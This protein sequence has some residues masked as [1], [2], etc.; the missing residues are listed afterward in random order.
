[1]ASLKT[2]FTRLTRA[3]GPARRFGGSAD[4]W[5][6]RYAAGG[7]AGSGSYGDLGHFK[8]E[9]LNGFVAEHTIADVVEFGCG[10][11]NQLGL[12]DY[13]RYLGFDVSAEAL[14]LCRAAF[15]DRA[16]FEFRHVDKDQGES[17]DLALSLDVIYHLVEDP[18]YEAYMARLFR[19]GRRFV[20]IYASNR[21]GA[22]GETPPHVR[23]RRF[24]DWVEVNAPAWDLY[25]FVEN[26]HPVDTDGGGS[27]ADFYFFAA[28][29]TAG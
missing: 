13:P 7:S 20:A 29:P 19:A 18:V 27:F 16:A 5:Q 15:A 12:A 28:P 8:A 10:D 14:E 17:A 4:Y 25:R 22:P 1:M 2:A 24:T 23:H 6:R 21:E 26:R 9:V 11:G 3:F